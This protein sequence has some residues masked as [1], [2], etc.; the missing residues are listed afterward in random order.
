MKHENEYHT[1]AILEGWKIH[2]FQIEILIWFQKKFLLGNLKKSLTTDLDAIQT[3]SYHLTQILIKKIFFCFV[4][5][6]RSIIPIYWWGGI[7]EKRT[8]KW[9]EECL[10]L[11][12][13]F[14]VCLL[15]TF[16][17]VFIKRIYNKYIGEI[18]YKSWIDFPQHASITCHHPLYA[19]LASIVRHVIIHQTIYLCMWLIIYICE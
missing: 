10:F 9:I 18:H 11:Q 2:L 14:M 6:R 17:I 7:W 1:F 12:Y 19:M 4:Q 8:N 13:A 5:A 3:A 16:E 15:I